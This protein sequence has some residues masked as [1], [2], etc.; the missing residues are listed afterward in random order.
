MSWNHRPVDNR[1][2]NRGDLGRFKTEDDKSPR[3]E[4]VSVTK[5]K[6]HVVV[7]YGGQTTRAHIPIKTFRKDCVN[8]WVTATAKA[9][10]EWIKEGQMVT[11]SAQ[12]GG[13]WVTQAQ[14]PE[15]R[16]QKLRSHQQV[17]LQDANVVIRSVRRDFTSCLVPRTGMLV[18]VPVPVIAAHG[19]IAPDRYRMLTDDDVDPFKND[20][21]E[22][23]DD[24]FAEL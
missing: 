11:L 15:G 8:W 7:W 13:L 6:S 3:F 5:D 2:W 14:I 19:F 20:N 23:L 21:L 24:L 1:R 22:D 9:P 10:P 16:Y 12:K 17:D 18:M 4:V